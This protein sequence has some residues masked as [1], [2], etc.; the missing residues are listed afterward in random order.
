MSFAAFASLVALGL[1]VP[2]AYKLGKH[3][4]HS[5]GHAAAARHPAHRT[6]WSEALIATDIDHEGLHLPAGTPGTARPMGGGAY[7]LCL[8]FQVLPADLLVVAG[9]GQ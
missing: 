7:E 9:E 4:G 5:E 6:P 1:S 2:A 8:S 3:V